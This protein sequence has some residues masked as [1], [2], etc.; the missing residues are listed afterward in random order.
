MSKPMI[1]SALHSLEPERRTVLLQ[2]IRYALAGFAITLA[3]AASYWAITDFLHVDPMVSFTIVFLAFSVISYVTHGEFSFKGHGTRDQHHIRMGRFLAV[4]VLGYVI[5]QGFIWVL[6]KQMGG[7][8]WWPTIPMI[9]VTPLITFALHR[10]Y[11][12][13]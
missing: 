3:V 6:V 10:R 11:V 2:L 1:Q 9:F 7:P 8:T 12:Y 13:S 5:N 4:N